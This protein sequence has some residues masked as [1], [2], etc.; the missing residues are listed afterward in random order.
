MLPCL[1]PLACLFL[2]ANGWT[3][4]GHM[5]VAQIA[6]DQLDYDNFSFIGEHF[7]SKAYL[8]ARGP[9][10]PKIEDTDDLAGIAVWM[11]DIKMAFPY[12][13]TWHFMD[14]PY[15]VDGTHCGPMEESNQ[16]ITWALNQ[17]TH[18]LTMHES[19]YTDPA[20]FQFF[21]GFWL[22]VLVHLVGDL[23]QP[24]HNMSG[25]SKRFHNGDRGGNLWKI[26]TDIH[27]T[28]HG[29]TKEVN[30]LHLLWDLAGG[31]YMDNWPLDD[32]KKAKLEAESKRLQKQ[33]PISDF[34]DVEY[35]NRGSF[36]RWHE[37]TFAY[38]AQVYDL[39]GAPFGKHITDKYLEFCQKTAQ[40]QITVAGYRLASLLKSLPEYK[41]A[42]SNEKPK[43]FL[44]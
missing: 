36:T 34:P 12:Q 11:D 39:E 33:F 25:C 7:Y 15:E 20:A 8:E 18:V 17:A 23:H 31:L 44:S 27:N 10:F 28:Y 3:D 9:D 43:T 2:V 6:K 32:E 1:F 19:K 38:A 35:K 41:Q 5:L 22:R 16:N 29:H 26:H 40:S 4:N 14:S 37:D 42:Y 24:L 13:T 30:E 21:H